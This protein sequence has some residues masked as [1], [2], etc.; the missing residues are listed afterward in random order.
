MTRSRLT[1][2]LC[3]LCQALP[4]LGADVVESTGEGES[5]VWSRAHQAAGEWWQ[6]SQES[7]GEWLELSREAAGEAWESTRGLLQESDQDHFG[8]VWD[9]VLPKL[10]QTLAL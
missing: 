7:A 3:L 8:R 6:R 2:L 4:A 5:K 1:A 10:E 9:R